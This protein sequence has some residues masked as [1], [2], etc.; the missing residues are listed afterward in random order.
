MDPATHNEPVEIALVGELTENEYQITE[1]LLDIPPGESCTLYIDSPGGSPYVAISLMSLIL[2]RGLNATG[3]VTGECSSSTLLPFAACKRRIVTPYSV[4]LFHPMKWQ[5]EDHVELAE[6]A[7]WARHFGELETEMDKLL[8]QLL[9]TS[10]D[11]IAK[12]VRPGRYVSGRELAES[13]LAE[14]VELTALADFSRNGHATSSTTRK[15]T[16]RHRAKPR[17]AKA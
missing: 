2:L 4:L 5:S 12:W 6:A 8:A 16:K 17:R 15:T 13:G 1:K 11:N 7:E 3:V 9:K 10:Y 14:L